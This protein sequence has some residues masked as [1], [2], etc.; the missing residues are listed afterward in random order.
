MQ[1]FLMYVLFAATVLALEYNSKE[2]NFCPH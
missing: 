2:N 1:G